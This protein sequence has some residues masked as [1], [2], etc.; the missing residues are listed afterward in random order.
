MLEKAARLAS[1]AVQKG[2]RDLD[3]ASRDLQEAIRNRERGEKALAE[4]AASLDGLRAELAPAFGGELPKRP[5]TVLEEREAKLASL[6]SSERTAAKAAD[7][8]VRARDDAERAIA[9]VR[10][11]S[12]RSSADL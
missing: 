7:A 10:S 12:S 11:E 4:V 3:G 2:Q 9:T 1:D 5:A 6:V 8:A